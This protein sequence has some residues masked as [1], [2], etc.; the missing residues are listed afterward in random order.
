MAEACSEILPKRRSHAGI[1]R[2]EKQG[3]HEDEAA[4][5]GGAHQDSKNESE[6]DC[7][8]LDGGAYSFMAPVLRGFVLPHAKSIAFLVAYRDFAIRL[9]LVLGI[10]VISAAF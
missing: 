6:P 8:F 3:Q 4:E 9:A 10:L 5:T 7:K 2:R 1:V